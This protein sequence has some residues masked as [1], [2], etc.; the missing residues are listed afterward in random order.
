MLLPQI[1]AEPKCPLLRPIGMTTI[2]RATALLALLA[3]VVVASGCGVGHR[4]PADHGA[5]PAVSAKLTSSQLGALRSYGATQMAQNA[6]RNSLNR[7]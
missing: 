5:A 2:R 6:H 3:S 1:A 7:W 4:R